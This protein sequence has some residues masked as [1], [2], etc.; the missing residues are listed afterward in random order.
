MVNSYGIKKMW[1]SGNNEQYVSAEMD[2]DEFNEESLQKSL[3]NS[4]AEQPHNKYDESLLD[5]TI[6]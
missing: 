6:S 1:V 5:N 2:T 4:N 3:D